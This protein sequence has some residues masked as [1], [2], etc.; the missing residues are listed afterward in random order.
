MSE[1]AA[2]LPAAD[3]VL[4]DIGQLVPL[5]GPLP[6]WQ[7]GWALP[8]SPFE[9][10]WPTRI[11]DAALASFGGNV[12]WC[13]PASQL[14]ASV[15]VLPGARR[16]SAS[17]SL[18]TP[19]FV[20]AHTH[21]VFGGTRSDEF[22]LRLRGV[23][24]RDLARSGGGILRTVR[25]TRNASAEQLLART[26]GRAARMLEWGTTTAEIKSGYGLDL[27]SEIK[28]LE[29]ARRLQAESPL[30]IVPTFLGAHEVP[31]GLTAAAYV[32]SVVQEMI[33]AVAESRLADFCDV[34]CERGVFDVPLARRVLEAASAHGLRLKLH[35]EQLSH[36]GGAALAADLHAQSAD[37]LE[38]AT[39]AD[40]EALA[41]AGVVGVLLPGAS[42]FLGTEHY[43]PMPAMRASGIEVALATD[44]N[45]GTCMTE[46]MASI[47]FLAVV[48]LRMSPGEALR[49][50]CLGAARAL[51]RADRIGSLES[52]KQTD[53]VVFDVPDLEHLVYHFGVNHVRTVLKRGQVVVSR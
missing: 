49:A 13:G 33:P 20:D 35:A 22:Y 31:P 21:L 17:G 44:C 30:E 46:S 32:E 14:A 4:Q 7:P 27:D 29:V 24:Y 11:P 47:L 51:G 52:G 10:P 1:P 41:S 9:P 36:F 8:P 37:H 3:L 19:G 16:L 42:V 34:F 38:H 25:E 28:I 50:A 48:K 53:L 2:S 43:A 15:D 45:P 39:P 40:L 12:V 26:A 23:A 6:T 5:A 18:V